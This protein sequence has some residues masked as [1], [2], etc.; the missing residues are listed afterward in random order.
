MGFTLLKISKNPIRTLTYKTLLLEGELFTNLSSSRHNLDFLSVGIGM[1]IETP[2]DKESSHNSR[3]LNNNSMLSIPLRLNGLLSFGRDHDLQT[4]LNLEYKYQ[5]HFSSNFY[6]KQSSESFYSLFSFLYQL[7][8][9]GNTEILL[10]GE[11]E[12]I[13]TFEKNSAN[14]E[15]KQINTKIGFELNRW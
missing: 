11:F 9:I 8:E 10:K 3:L 4:R 6:N 1:G 2:W 15:I 7:G 13:D 12:Y 5:F 14:K